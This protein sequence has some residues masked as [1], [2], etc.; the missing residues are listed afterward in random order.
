MNNAYL[1]HIEPWFSQPFTNKG[2][3]AGNLI[4]SGGILFTGNHFMRVILMSACN[5]RFFEKG[6][7]CYIQRKYLWPVVNNHYIVQQREIDPAP[8]VWLH[9]SVG[10]ASH[11]YRGGHGFE[12]S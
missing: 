6:T 11:R 3:A 7:F 9:S 1:K 10:R 4:C 2:T 12:S 5:I 8:N